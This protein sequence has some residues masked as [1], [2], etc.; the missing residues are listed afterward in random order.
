MQYLN[1]ASQMYQ[2]INYTN[3][4]NCYCEALGKLNQDYIIKF[5]SSKYDIGFFQSIPLRQI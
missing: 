2:I 5:I 1:S 3:T 4:T